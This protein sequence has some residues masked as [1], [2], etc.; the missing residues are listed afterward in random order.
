MFQRDDSLAVAF[1]DLQGFASKQGDGG[2]EWPRV[3][4]GIQLGQRTVGEVQ[5]EITFRSLQPPD[6]FRYQVDVH[7][8]SA[9]SVLSRPMIQRLTMLNGANIIP[10]ARK[11]NEMIAVCYC[12]VRCD[13]P[14]ACMPACHDLPK[15]IQNVSIRDGRDAD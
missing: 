9:R 12:S 15:L 13:F 8:K 5:F 7:G 2:L 4:N 14:E 6:C 1:L 3:F 11:W 10:V